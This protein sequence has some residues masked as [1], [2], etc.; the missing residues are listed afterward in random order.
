MV[1]GSEQLVRNMISNLRD[2]EKCTCGK[3]YKI[4]VI[5]PFENVCT[6]STCNIKAILFVL[7]E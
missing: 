3:Y 1:N 7:H 4:R 5:R 2:T 6:R